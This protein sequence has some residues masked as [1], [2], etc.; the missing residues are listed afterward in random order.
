MNLGTFFVALVLVV[1]VGLVIRSLYKDKKAGKH[2]CG[3]NCGA[4]GMCSG[5]ADPSQI[6]SA[7]EKR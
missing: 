7:E 1:I 4:C 6:H 2:S 3:G 5:P